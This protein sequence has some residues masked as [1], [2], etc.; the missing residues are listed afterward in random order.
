MLLRAPAS[1]FTVQDEKKEEGETEERLGLRTHPATLTL[2]EIKAHFVMGFIFSL[3]PSI[4]ST[5]IL[6]HVV[7]KIIFKIKLCFFII[8]KN[9]L[10]S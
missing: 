9:K 6:I 1:H 8:I 7:R 2:V 10:K 4:Y 3:H 5:S